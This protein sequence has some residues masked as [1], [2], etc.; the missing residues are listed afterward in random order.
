MAVFTLY[1][2]ML[3]AHGV[4]LSIQTKPL[5]SKITHAIARSEIPSHRKQIDNKPISI[6]ENGKVKA[7]NDLSKFK[8]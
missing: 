2:V 5:I 6:N 1:G 7:K 4:I 8:T 3:M